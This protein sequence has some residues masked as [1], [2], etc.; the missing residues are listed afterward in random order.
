MA[1]AAL[2]S[3]SASFLGRSMRIFIVTLALI[4]FPL[5][6]NAEWDRSVHQHPFDGNAVSSSVYGKT[7]GGDW[8]VLNFKRWEETGNTI[9]YIIYTNGE[10]NCR[11]N[12]KI[13]VKVDGASVDATGFVD[14]E[15]DVQFRDAD[16]W[17]ELLS[18][19]K[20]LDIRVTDSCRDSTTMSFDVTGSPQLHF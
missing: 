14:N 19:G 4:L 11:G 3:F 7:I 6:G 15:N 5:Y 9:L 2:T 16:T 17:V 13:E 12:V 18:K 10:Y 20:R 1:I 8:I